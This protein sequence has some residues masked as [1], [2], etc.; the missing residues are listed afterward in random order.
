MTQHP[1]EDGSAPVGRA[2]DS[3]AGVLPMLASTLQDQIEA[4]LDTIGPKS[5]VFAPT[6][7]YLLRLRQK[8]MSYQLNNGGTHE[9]TDGWL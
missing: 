7:R 5:L 9:S 3:F 1:L 2:A 4:S 6:P 8:A